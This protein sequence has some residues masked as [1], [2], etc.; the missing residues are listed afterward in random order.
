MYEIELQPNGQ[1]TT[2]VD[3][4][5]LLCTLVTRFNYSAACWT[6]DIFDSNDVALLTGLMLVPNVNILNPHVQ[7]RQMIGALVLI[8]QAD[9]YYKDPELLGL[10]TKLLWFPPGVE[11]VIPI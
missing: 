6:M 7:V 2:I 8:E 9:G 1:T 4:G 3:M 10:A 5:T 11:V